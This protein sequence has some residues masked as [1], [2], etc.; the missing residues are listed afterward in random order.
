MNK[1][2]GR[3]GFFSIFFSSIDF[4]RKLIL[5]L[6][7]WGLVVAVIY[8]LIPSR[9]NIPQGSVL[10]LQPV[11]TIVERNDSEP[12]AD[13]MS[14]FTGN[15]TET[16]LLYLSRSIRTAAKDE[17]I[18]SLFL[19]LSGLQYASL[20]ALQELESDLQYFKSTNK[21]IIAWSSYYNLYAALL[22]STADEVY[23]DPMG[24]VSL[25]GYSVYRTYYADAMEKWNLE[26]AYFHAGEFKSYG[27][28]YIASEMS[29]DM[30]R[31][32]QRWLDELWDQYLSTLAINRELS[33]DDLKNWI[34]QYPDMIKGA[35][36]SEAEAALKA[37]LIDGILTPIELDKELVRLTGS[38]RKDMIWGGDYHPVQDGA[39]PGEKEVYVLTAS[40]QIHGGESRPWSIGSDTVVNTLDRISEDKNIAALV[41]RLDTGGGSAFA[42]EL[43]RRKLVEMKKKGTR[44]VVSM[45]GVTA[46]GGYWIASAADEIWSAPGTITGS[47]G[48]FTMVPQ[49]SGFT[50]GTLNLHSDGVGTTWMSG[51][52]RLDQPLNEQ[53]RSVFQTTV[54]QTYTQFLDLVAESRSMSVGSLKP[55]AE[56]RIWTGNEALANG[57]ADHTGTLNQA[58]ESAALLARLDDY[59]VEYHKEEPLNMD[60]VLGSIQGIRMSGISKFLESL[61]PSVSED[62]LNLKPGHV[63]A[64][65]H[66]ANR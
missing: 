10:M 61:L 18:S 60:D 56:G 52:G 30:K 28:P 40:G 50:E 51:Q 13:W 29:R 38:E 9:V 65:S 16:P 39:I 23:M 6:I 8:S 27:E 31:E 53:S 47:I 63:Y 26:M 19:D 37:S 34:A 44:I 15:V 42:S 20:A 62:I 2:S 4:I 33:S 57:L 64:L 59:R 35:E 36:N 46:S 14:S 49:I 55:L 66:V 43:I 1:T 41:L 5:N 3:R 7:F 54:N 25:P 21:K 24:S 45:G 11:G 48:V 32:N 12:M 22:A 58:I 17:R